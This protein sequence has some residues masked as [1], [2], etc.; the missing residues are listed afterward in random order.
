MDRTKRQAKAARDQFQQQPTLDAPVEAEVQDLEQMVLQSR[1][2][3]KAA[4]AAKQRAASLRQELLDLQEEE[5]SIA[6]SQE[7]LPASAPVPVVVDSAP[8]PVATDA[9][10]LVAAS[11]QSAVIF[12]IYIYSRFITLWLTNLSKELTP[13]TFFWL[14]TILT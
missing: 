8:A 11:L 13:S 1:E 3:V 14:R 4:K 5:Q 7:A 2:R 6:A 9:G 10:A 12:I